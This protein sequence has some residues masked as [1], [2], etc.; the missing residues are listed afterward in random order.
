MDV[1]DRVKPRISYA[2]KKRSTIEIAESPE[3]ELQFA[4][5]IKEARKQNFSDF[6]KLPILRLVGTDLKDRPVYMF[7]PCFVKKESEQIRRAILYVISTMNSELSVDGTVD[8]IL[9]YCNTLMSF[10]DATFSWMLKCWRCFPRRFKKTLKGLY[11]VHGDGPF[12]ALVSAVRPLVSVK[13]WLKLHFVAKLEDLR[14]VVRMTVLQFE[15]LFPYPI[16]RWEAEY[17]S[18][19]VLPSYF[20]SRLHKQCRLYAM[21]YGKFDNVPGI[22]AMLLD[23]LTDKSNI[24]TKDLVN[25][26]TPLE[27][28]QTLI[29]Q[30]DA[31]DQNPGMNNTAAVV[32]VLKTWLGA[33]PDCLC[34]KRGCAYLKDEWLKLEEE[35]KEKAEGISMDKIRELAPKLAKECVAYI[36][37][38]TAQAIVAIIEFLQAVDKESDE[39]EGVLRSV[40]A[41]TFAGYFFR[42]RKFEP[43]YASMIPLAVCV[44][45]E[46]IFNDEIKPAEMLRPYY[47]QT[48]TSSLTGRKKS[49]LP[50]WRINVTTE[51]AAQG[52]KRAASA[53]HPR[54]MKG[55]SSSESSD[56]ERESEK[57]RELEKEQKVEDQMK[58]PPNNARR[59]TI[60]LTSPLSKTPK[61]LTKEDSDD[62]A[63]SSAKSSVSPNRSSPSPVRSSVG[64]SSS[65]S[66]SPPKTKPDTQTN[67]SPETRGT[68]DAAKKTEIVQNSTAESK[69]KAVE[70]SVVSEEFILKKIEANKEK[71]EEGKATDEKN[72]E[73]K[74]KEEDLIGAGVEKVKP[75]LIRNEGIEEKNKAIDEKVKEADN[76]TNKKKNETNSNAQINNVSSESSS[77]ASSS[78]DSESTA[79]KAKSKN[80]VASAPDRR[81]STPPENSAGLLAPKNQE[82]RRG[83]APPVS[84]E[85][86][87]SSSESDSDS[88]DNAKL[89]TTPKAKAKAES[90][91]SQSKANPKSALPKSKVHEEANKAAGSKTSPKSALPKSKVSEDTKKIDSSSSSSSQESAEKQTVR[92]KSMPVNRSLAPKGSGGRSKSVVVSAPK[93]IKKDGTG[94]GSRL[95]KNKKK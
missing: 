18:R 79:P 31:G 64:A 38:E 20:G 66:A 27:P 92:K 72:A 9:I 22:L 21:P 81:L 84:K 77:S 46:L 45:E 55:Q 25:L 85:S 34:S 2:A 88:S 70:K 75:E 8:Y 95:D 3:I 14:S 16:V 71:H 90:K 60:T 6:T 41:A 76:D 33:L 15:T 47:H 58:M 52:R 50:S 57:E 94:S 89:K 24:K 42:P 1:P 17:H 23:N 48:S 12:R 61:L 35:D 32:C 83:T 4:N 7:A 62:S 74:Q 11:I 82:S 44:T 19:D 80:L 43:V 93:N 29:D 68:A 73:T 26:Q 13:F 56:S 5:L 54:E 37:P 36:I 86:S 30:I 65:P 69:A 87:S 10:T 91:T 59:P 49:V 40:I 53:K 63:E 39:G 78:S 28:A 67:E 51:A